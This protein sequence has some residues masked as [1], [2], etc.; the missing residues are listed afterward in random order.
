MPTHWPADP[1]TP[2]VWGQARRVWSLGFEAGE[3]GDLENLPPQFSVFLHRC[4]H[5][6]HQ[7]ILSGIID[8]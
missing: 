6:H 5:R 1:H 8:L 7:S 4:Q 3:A 2:P